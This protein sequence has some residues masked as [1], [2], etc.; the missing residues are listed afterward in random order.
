[1]LTAAIYA[2]KSKLSEKGDSVE[3]QIRKCESHLK[4]IDVTN[5][6][7]YKDD[8]FSGK[9]TSRPAFT[10][11][12]QDAKDKKFNILI[13]YKFDRVSRNVTDF[14]NLVDKL[15][16]LDISFISLS[17]QFD[18]S[19]PIG[20]AMMNICSVFSQLERETT[21]LR[22]TDNMYALAELGYWLGGECPTGFKN[23]R[24]TYQDASG[25]QKSY[26]IL[27]PIDEELTLVNLIYD[28][29]LSFKSLSKLEKY[30]LSNNIKTKRQKDFSKAALA[31]ILRNP[32]Y[33]KADNT[34]VEYLSTQK[35]NMFGTPDGVHGLLIYKRRKGKNGKLNDVGQWI[36]SVSSHEGILNPETWINA[37]KLLDENKAKAPALGCSNT[38][39]LSG[40]V[41]CAKCNK[42][43]RVSFGDI[44]PHTNTKRY[45][46][47]CTLKHNS[48]KTR[49]DCRNV[50]GL[51]LD[52]IV[53]SK[54]KELSIDKNSL[55]SELIKHSNKLKISYKNGYY[56]S[57]TNEIEA[58]NSSIN[59]LLTNMS[60]TT[61]ADVVK[62]L[63][64][65][66]TSLKNKNNELKL[67]IEEINN[68]IASQS[69]LINNSSK[70]IQCLKNISL[71][72][73][74]ATIAEKK[75]LVASVIERVIVNGDTGA[76]SIR[77]KQSY[78]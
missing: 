15:T 58:N 49:C 17:E 37:Q 32:C 53:I 6:L 62:I 68:E 8:G 40:L 22:V 39:L 3:N 18:T 67:K 20:K 60:L 38:A 29:Y 4:N 71:F 35:I 2:R 1:M 65:K 56:S 9:D 31:T 78:D 69:D 10:K 14:S 42:P 66:I 45:Y 27:E 5:I 44:I 25:K 30:M 63:L 41:T 43:M 47:M 46:Y 28:K 16:E 74:N 64:E 59:N 61:D 13:C 24:L 73:D 57:I 34:V 36:Y 76:V 21:C 12:M 7:V 26:S 48:G 33:V 72:I 54:L 23:K 52:T 50:N 51:D 70:L 75:Q 11:M 19:S 77:F 55:I